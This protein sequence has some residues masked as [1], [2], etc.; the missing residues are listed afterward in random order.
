MIGIDNNGDPTCAGP[1]LAGRL[2]TFAENGSGTCTYQASCST[3]YPACSC[4]CSAG[5]WSGGWWGGSSCSCSCTS[6]ATASCSNNM[7][8][9]P[10]TAVT[11]PNVGNPQGASQLTWCEYG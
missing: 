11:C 3:G 5:W 4:S 7:C 2:K 6:T 10:A 1:Q 8:T 9:A